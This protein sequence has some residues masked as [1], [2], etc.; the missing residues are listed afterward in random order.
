MLREITD[1]LSFFLCQT[2]NWQAVVL[3]ENELC[4]AVKSIENI[5]EKNNKKGLA[6]LLLV[7]KITEDLTS[8]ISEAEVF[9]TPTILADA[10][11]HNEAIKLKNYL[12][13]N[14]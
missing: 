5:M 4:A 12:D 1:G 3:A 6:A 2:A 14:E 9:F 7:K 11:F 8:E 10:G 13:K